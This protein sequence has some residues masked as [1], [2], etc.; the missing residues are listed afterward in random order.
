[1]EVFSG[2]DPVVHQEVV[3]PVSFNAPV[4]KFEGGLYPNHSRFEVIDHRSGKQVDA[5]GI[6]AM[7]RDGVM[8]LR[9]H[10]LSKYPAE[11]FE[12][13]LVMRSKA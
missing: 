13:Y 6:A 5:R 12:I 8:W 7:P 11:G 9:L 10:L 1:M 4:P 2:V 3:Y